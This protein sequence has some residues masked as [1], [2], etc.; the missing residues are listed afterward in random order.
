MKRLLTMKALTKNRVVPPDSSAGSP[1]ASV[2]RKTA[3]SCVGNLMKFNA[4]SVGLVAIAFAFVL[5]GSNLTVSSAQVVNA[6]K[7]V[8]ADATSCLPQSITL[9][10]G[11]AWNLCVIAVQGNGLILTQV[12]FKK[13][14]ASQLIEILND[15]R[16]AEIF[17]PYHAGTPRFDDIALNFPVSPLTTADCPSPNVI[18]DGQICRE[19]RDYGVAWRDDKKVRR[20]R[21]LVYWAVLDAA[22]Y[23]YIMEWSFRD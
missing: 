7:A 12:N 15:A 21:E 18:L 4:K 13:N 2:L 8:S 16:I 14:A 22:N 19:I 6:G 17:V 10:A 11:S 3:I 5:L 9:P 1:P 20:G 23:N